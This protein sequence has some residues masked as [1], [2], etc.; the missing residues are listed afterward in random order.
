MPNNFDLVFERTTHLTI[1][2]IWQ[3]WTEPQ[4]LMKWFCPRPWKVT[5]CRLDLKAGGEFYTLMQSPEGQEFP[6]HG[7]FLEIIPN[8]KLVWTNMMFKDFKPNPDAQ[9][10]FPFTVMLTLVKSDQETHYKA[11]VAHADE[12]GKKQHEEMGFYVGWGSA[13]DQLEEM[14]K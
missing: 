12:K 11:V 1:D 7:S 5:E 13:F 2:Q 4:N 3:A 8:N 6:N 14:Y 9:L 10:G